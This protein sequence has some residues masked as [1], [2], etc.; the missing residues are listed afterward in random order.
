MHD[1]KRLYCICHRFDVE[2]GV[3][4]PYMKR[5]VCTDT[6]ARVTEALHG[7]ERG[8][9]RYGVVYRV[10]EAA[11]GAEEAA[12]AEPTDEHPEA[13]GKPLPP[14]SYPSLTSRSTTL[15]SGLR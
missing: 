3:E 1:G 11:A 6:C 15:P 14:K 4:L 13:E 9:Q 12:S 7:M 8:M 2:E 5:A 10:A